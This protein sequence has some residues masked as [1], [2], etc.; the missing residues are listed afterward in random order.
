MSFA[1][2][3][4]DELLSLNMKLNLFEYGL[5]VNGQ[6]TDVKSSKYWDENYKTMSTSE[7]ERYKGGICWDYVFY[8][9]YMLKKLGIQHMQRL[10]IYQQKILLI[11]LLLIIIH[12]LKHSKI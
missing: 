11:F 6:I 8:Q 10:K 2:D 1:T 5:P 12:S 4:R 7:F 9:D 3:V